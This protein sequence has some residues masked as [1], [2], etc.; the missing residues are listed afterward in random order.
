MLLSSESLLCA[1]SVMCFFPL[2]PVHL[3]NRVFLLQNNDGAQSRGP[4]SGSASFQVALQCAACTPQGSPS[5]EMAPDMNRHKQALT[6]SAAGAYLALINMAAGLYLLVF[7]HQSDKC[8]SD[9][10]EMHPCVL[11]TL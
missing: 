3:S 4:G 1:V 10:Q 8:G 5:V 6:T 2:A 7:Q 9:R 11:L